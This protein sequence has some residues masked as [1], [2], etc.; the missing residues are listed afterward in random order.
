[1]KHR[2][3]P[4]ALL[5]SGALLASVSLPGFAG[6]K[7]TGGLIGAG[8]GTVIGHGI[9]GNSGAVVGAVTGAALGVAIA[10]RDDGHGADPRYRYGAHES[11]HP[12]RPHGQAYRDHGANGDH[13]HGP[14]SR[15]PHDR[16]EERHDRRHGAYR[17]APHARGATTTLHSQTV[18]VRHPA[19]RPAHGHDAHVHGRQQAA[20]HEHGHGVR[21]VQA[22][23]PR[24]N[25]H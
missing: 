22:H 19:P 1:M 2:I 18:V 7:T 17:V 20:Y 15:H 5:L 25:R 4:L 13:R 21:D 9:G 6:D 16:H 3:R 23:G 11:F 14:Q 12:P 8:V 10:S 24:G